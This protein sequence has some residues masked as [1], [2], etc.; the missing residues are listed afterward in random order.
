MLRLAIIAALGFAGLGFVVSASAEDTPEQRQVSVTG[1]YHSNYN[2]VKLS[3]DGNRVYGTYV[4]C[5]GGTIEG[6]I[7]EGRTIRYV[8]RQPNSWGLGVWT[9]ERGRLGG[10]WGT[11]Q[12]E[13][14]GGRWDLVIAKSNQQLAK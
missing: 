7:I 4:C 12:N 10:T 8:W 11:G 13:T 2:D 3:Q 9:I 6:K 5:G 14:S 1:T